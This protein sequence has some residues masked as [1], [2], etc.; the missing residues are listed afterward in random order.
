[1]P[2]IKKVLTLVNTGDEAKAMLAENATLAD[3]LGNAEPGHPSLYF[4]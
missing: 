4:Y 3:T 2:A 1:M